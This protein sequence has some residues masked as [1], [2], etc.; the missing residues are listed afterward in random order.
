MDQSTASDQTAPVTTRSSS[1]RAILLIARVLFFLALI[2]CVATFL[3]TFRYDVN[4]HSDYALWIGG[5]IAWALFLSTFGDAPMF[6][7]RPRW[8]SIWPLLFLMVAFAAC[9]LPFYDNWRWAYTGDSFGVYSV[10]HYLHKTGL[11]TSLLSVHGIDDAFTYL[12]EIT[13]CWPMYFFGPELIWHRVGQLIIALAA[14][15]AI[16]FFFRMLVGNLWAS[17]IVVATA[18]NYVWLWVTYISYYKIDSNIFYFVMLAWGLLIWRYPERLGLWM[19]AGLTAGLSLFY[20]PS[21]W[22]GIMAVGVFVAVYGLFQRRI[23]AVAVAALSFPLISIPILLELPHMI[24]MVRMQ[25][26]PMDAGR[27]YFFPG[28]DYTYKI[29]R[30]IMMAPYDSFID[31][32]GVNGPFFQL[33]LGHA[34]LVG[35]GLAAITL[36]PW[37]RRKLSVPAATPLL[38]ALLVFDAMLLALSNKGYGNVS[39]KR[40]YNI[41]PLQM[42]F[43]IL[44]F[45]VVYMLG[46][47]RRW[48]RLLVVGTTAVV[49]VFYGA[50]NARAILNPHNGMYGV[51]IYDGLIQL[52]Q[53]DP[54]RQVFV[55]TSRNFG[56]ALS[57]ESLFQYVYHLMDN[58]TMTAEF[59]REEFERACIPGNL[60]CYEPNFDQATFQPLVDALPGRLKRFE[61]VNTQE[62]RCF[63]C[64]A[65]KS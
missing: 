63:E 16:Y 15:A 14:L 27:Q 58:V 33:P 53:T 18:M 45:Y 56:E 42:Y 46:N 23:G 64:V 9:W 31:K 28:F 21:A 29:F 48:W 6:G 38:L 41:I 36:L 22:A 24:A 40:S 10:T 60:L 62:M 3:D 30:E 44:P 11:R 20:T 32:L 55:F 37:L 50:M 39:H 49:L 12:W 52:R 51:N 57:K 8:Q 17:I 25:S 26:T 13:Y 59:T 4:Q 34:Y 19:M 47:A 65:P 2:A 35:L 54:Q 7:L 5:V 43:A 1:R 61:V